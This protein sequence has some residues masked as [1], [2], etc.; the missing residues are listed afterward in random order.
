MPFTNQAFMAFLKVMGIVFTMVVLAGWNLNVS[1][2][3]QEQTARLL[4]ISL[5]IGNLGV[6]DEMRFVNM[7]ISHPSLTIAKKVGFIEVRG[8]AKFD[9]LTSTRFRLTFSKP[10]VIDLV[11]AETGRPRA[12]Q[13]LRTLVMEG[14]PATVDNLTLLSGL[15]TSFDSMVISNKDLNQVAKYIQAKISSE[16]EKYFETRAGMYELP[17]LFQLD[18]LHIAFSL[19]DLRSS[20]PVVPTELRLM[21]HQVI[22]PWGDLNMETSIFSFHIV[23][24][25]W[26]SDSQVQQVLRLYELGLKLEQE[27]FKKKGERSRTL[28]NNVIPFPG[29]RCERKL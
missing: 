10:L 23:D 25:R 9:R 22:D 5:R 29:K 7:P 14:A 11:D 3:P 27:R 24:A 28:P 26:L 4:P 21:A 18:S 19:A 20:E 1:A 2:Q 15:S 13:L 17:E 6:E 8:F 16:G 12:P